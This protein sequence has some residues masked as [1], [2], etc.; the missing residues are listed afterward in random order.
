VALTAK[1]RTGA[2]QKSVWL[3]PETIAAVG[4]WAEAQGATFSAALE[5][6]ARVGLGQAVAEAVAPVIASAVRREVRAQ[7]D[8]LASLL[9][10]VAI[11]AGIG[12]RLGNATLRELAPERVRAIAQAARLASVDALKRR[13]PARALGLVDE[14]DGDHEGEL[15]QSE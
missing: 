13:G 12:M 7:V 11:D 6:L 1:R 15:P 9:A 14:D 5:S 10:A 8:R 4:A 2:V 3:S